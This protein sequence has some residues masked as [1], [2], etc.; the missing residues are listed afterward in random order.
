M[1]VV[2]V[3]EAKDHLQLTQPVEDLLIQS[4]I[5]SAEAAIGKLV[6]PLEPTAV[7]ERVRAG[8]AT[9]LVVAVTPAIS[10]TSITPI[11]GTA[12]DLAGIDI[13]PAG[14]ITA[15]TAAPFTSRAY[16]VVYQAGRNPCPADLLMAVKELI[17]VQWTGAVNGGRGAAPRGS[18]RAANTVKGAE[19]TMPFEVSR[20]LAPHML[21]SGF[22]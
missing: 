10:I 14:I 19:G 11:D 7:T 3:P 5:D 4:Y 21:A 22:A 13:D 8:S 20:L 6:G 16:T 15:D 12:L 18:E 9:V 1:S 17:R 2:S